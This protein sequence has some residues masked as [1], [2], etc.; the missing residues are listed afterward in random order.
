MKPAAGLGLLGLGLKAGTV[1]LGTNGVRAALQ[2]GDLA[3]VVLARDLS[4]RTEEKVARL[5]RGAG[6]PV[7]VGPTARE[8]GQRLGREQVQTVGVRDHQLAKGLRYR[9]VEDAPQGEEQ[10]AG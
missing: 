7:L 8:L 2:K 3:L 6:V 5:A 4:G 9:W 10:E 1:I